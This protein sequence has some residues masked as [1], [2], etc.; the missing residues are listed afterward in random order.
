MYGPRRPVTAAA[1]TGHS[2]GMK[3]VENRPARLVV[4][5]SS[6]RDV[7]KPCS[8]KRLMPSS[9]RVFSQTGSL[10]SRSRRKRMKRER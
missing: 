6:S 1:A 4:R 9:R 8:L 5:H 2:A 3:A 10:P 7:G